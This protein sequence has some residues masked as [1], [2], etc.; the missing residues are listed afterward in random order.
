MMQIRSNPAS[1][2]ELATVFDILQGK[3][4]MIKTGKLSRADLSI[5]FKSFNEPIEDFEVDDIFKSAGLDDTELGMTL[6]EFRTLYEAV[7]NSKTR[8]SKD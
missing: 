5:A 8:S 7:Q 3:R 4:D 2:N 6:E 1:K